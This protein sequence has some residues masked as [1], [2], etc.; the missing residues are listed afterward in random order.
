[1][2]SIAPAVMARIL[3]ASLIG[4]N[5]IKTVTCLL[6]RMMRPAI[7]GTTPISICSR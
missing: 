7:L 4:T 6:H 1:M 3:E 5:E 2:M